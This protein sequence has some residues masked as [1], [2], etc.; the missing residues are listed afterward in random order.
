MGVS[1]VERVSQCLLSGRLTEACT[2]LRELV[3]PQLAGVGAGVNQDG[4][5]GSVAMTGT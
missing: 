3:Q 5:R 4:E 1:L 2:P